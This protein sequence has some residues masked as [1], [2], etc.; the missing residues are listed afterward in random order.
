MFCTNNIHLKWFTV[1]KP[2][3]RAKGE[4][5][6]TVE[7]SKKN[8][9]TKTNSSVATRMCTCIRSGLQSFTPSL[10]LNRKA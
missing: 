8:A 10:R 1:K 6:S 3:Q 2:Q 5:Q 4:D 9:R 7:K